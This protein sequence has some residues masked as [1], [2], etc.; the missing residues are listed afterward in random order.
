MLLSTQPNGTF[1]LSICLSGASDWTKAVG[2]SLTINTPIWLKAG[3]T[4]TRYYL[5]E[6]SDG[7]TYTE[8]GGFDST[9]VTKSSTTFFFGCYQWGGSNWWGSFNG[10]IDLSETSFVNDGVTIW[11]PYTT[12]DKPA[13]TVDIGSGASSPTSSTEGYVGKLYV[14]TGG[15]VY[16]CTGVS[17]STY[18]WAQLTTS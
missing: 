18:T 6:S 17:G 9:T 2:S 10:S 12:L 11:T 8:T 14:T 16:I 1:C 13:I 5:K 4:G 7:I 3:W 15:S